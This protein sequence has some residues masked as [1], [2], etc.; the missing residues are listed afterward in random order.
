MQKH[1]RRFNKIIFEVPQR[2]ETWNE[3]NFHIDKTCNF[4]HEKHIKLYI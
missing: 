1:Q 4:K 3:S 2:K